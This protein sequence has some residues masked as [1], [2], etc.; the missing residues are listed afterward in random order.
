M[1][2]GED[3]AG[4]KKAVSGRNGVIY[5]SKEDFILKGIY[6]INITWT[7][8]ANLFQFSIKYMIF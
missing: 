1:I 3:Q 6:I 4:G 2:T 5:S 8:N 7:F